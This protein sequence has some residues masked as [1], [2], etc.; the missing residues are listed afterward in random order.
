[1]TNV[2]L[3]SNIVITLGKGHS[4]ID[5]ITDKSIATTEMTRLEVYG[6]HLITQ[7]EEKV[8]NQFFLHIR[9]Y[10]ISRD[11]I[12]K[13]IIFRQTKNTSVGDAKI[14]AT[15]FLYNLP[16]YTANTDDFIHLSEIQ[17]INEF[18]L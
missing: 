2:F 13:A 5:I 15:A 1:M 3:D 10:S 8:L 4:P 17:L 12:D 7:E 9:C 14:A 11:I 6:H 16:L 18:H